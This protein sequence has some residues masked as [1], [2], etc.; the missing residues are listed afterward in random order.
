M[1]AVAGDDLVTR[2]AR[3]GDADG[4]RLLADVEVTEAADEAHA[5]HLAGLFLE[6]ADQEHVAIGGEFLIAGQGS[7]VRRAGGRSLLTS[8]GCGR[9]HERFPCTVAF[10]DPVRGRT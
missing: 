3:R 2:A 4:D 8:I 1:I 7:L 9:C 5:V 6:S 10:G